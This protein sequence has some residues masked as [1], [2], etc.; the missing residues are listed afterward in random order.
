MCIAPN[1]LLIEKNLFQLTLYAKRHI[2]ANIVRTV[3]LFNSNVI[4]DR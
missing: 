2:I 1:L 4:Y 3:V